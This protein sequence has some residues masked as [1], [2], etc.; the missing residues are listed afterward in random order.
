[1]NKKS[2][3]NLNFS[4][5]LSL[6]IKISSKKQDIFFKPNNTSLD[7]VSSPIKNNKKVIKR[8]T[9][10]SSYNSFLYNQTENPLANKNNLNTNIISVDSTNKINLKKNNFA[11]SNAKK[12][13]NDNSK[14]KNN[15]NIKKKKKKKEWGSDNDKYTEIDFSS[16]KTFLDKIHSKL[17]YL[18]ACQILSM[19]YFCLLLVTVTSSGVSIMFYA[20][21][22]RQGYLITFMI[23]LW[24]IIRFFIF[25]FFLFGATYG[26][27]FL[28]FRD[29]MAIVYNVFEEKDGKGSENDIKGDILGESQKFYDF[30]YF[31]VEY[32]CREIETKEKCYCD[33]LENDINLTYRVLNDASSESQKLCALSLCSAFFGEIAV[34]FFLLVLHHYNND[35][36]F[37]SGKSI[38]KGF[39]GF[40]G[41]YKKKN[42][43]KEPAYKKRKL[44]A[45][46][47]L[48]SK[49]DDIADFKGLNKNENDEED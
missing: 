6:N 2:K 46:I 13:L 35:N 38:F 42:L 24:N 44:R 49:N 22:K 4:K 43:N 26:I 1:M 37:D 10:T 7:F 15:N 25:S 19:I 45:E 27:L 9:R 12:T 28:I 34:I 39:N 40:E 31:D 32:T 41:G 16:F 14:S 33:F 11:F 3:N 48:T 47:E 20:C 18:K 36:F 8:N 5:D 30:C 17:N 23:V 29:A 21:L